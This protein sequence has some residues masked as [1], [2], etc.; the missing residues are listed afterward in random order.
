MTKLAMIETIYK[1]VPSDQRG[2]LPQ[3]NRIGKNAPTS[4]NSFSKP[5]SNV[6]N[7]VSGRG[8]ID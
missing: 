5:G 2:F 1:Q 4:F 8:F 7:L 6:S 3:T